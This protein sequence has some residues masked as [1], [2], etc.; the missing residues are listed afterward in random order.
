M[1]IKVTEEEKKILKKY[2]ID[3]EDYNNLNELLLEIDDAM[4]SYVDE[5]DEPLPEFLELEKL[6]DSIFYAN[7]NWLVLCISKISYS[8]LLH[9]DMI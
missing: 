9:S 6:Y 5:N 3:I 4:T 2:N 8:F 7:K 1:N